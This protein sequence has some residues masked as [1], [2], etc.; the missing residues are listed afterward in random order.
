MKKAKSRKVPTIKHRGVSIRELNPSCFQVDMMRGGHRERKS[1][2]TVEEAK[3]YITHLCVDIENRGIGALR[4][5]PAQRDDAYAALQLLD[6]RASLKEA[7]KHLVKA[8]F[9][10]GATVQQVAD[11]Y[12]EG[13]RRRGLRP[14]SLNNPEVRSRI[15]CETFGERVADSISTSEL[16]RFLEDRGVN[17]SWNDWRQTMYAMYKAGIK[18]MLCETNPAEHIDKIRRDDKAPQIYSVSQCKKLLKTAESSDERALMHFVLGLFCGLRPFEAYGAD[19]SHVDLKEKTLSVVASA[20]KSRRQRIVD[21]SNTAIDW[22]GAYMRPSGPIGFTGPNQQKNVLHRDGL[23]SAAGVKW[24]PDG[25]RHTFASYTYAHSGDA[26]RTAAIMGHSGLDIF[27][28]HYRG[29]AT[30]KDAEKFFAIRPAKQGKIIHLKSG[31]A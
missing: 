12:L 1:F 15:L 10:Q 11:C 30:K 3:V 20:S 9:A 6:G 23:L 8:K 26:A 29:L 21:L 31:A 25:L 4:L 28:R 7:A 13:L 24:I 18:S 17:R 14:A 5:S 2:S 22:L 16:V 27:F 19:W